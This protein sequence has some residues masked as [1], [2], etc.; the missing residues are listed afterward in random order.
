MLLLLFAQ[1]RRQPHARAV[2]ARAAAERSGDPSGHA[3]AP[4]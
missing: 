3:R 4:A 1:I 2:A